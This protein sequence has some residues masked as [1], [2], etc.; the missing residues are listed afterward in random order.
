MPCRWSL[1]SVQ[2]ARSPPAC[3]DRSTSY[4]P[5]RRASAGPRVS[6]S[7]W[8]YLPVALVLVGEVVERVVEPVLDRELAGVRRVGGEVGVDARLP[9][10]VPGPEPP[11]VAAAGL[12]RI[13]W[14]IDV[15]ARGECPKVSRGRCALHDLPLRIAQQHVPPAQDDVD[16][17]GTVRLAGPARLRLRLHREHR[18]VRRGQP[19]RCRLRD[20]SPSGRR[21]ENRDHERAQPHP[22]SSCHAHSVRRP[23]NIAQKVRAAASR[24]ETL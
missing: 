18:R 15:V 4:G 23:S 12:E 2:S 22:A 17:G 19:L 6:K 13:A 10:V 21:D 16:A 14:E 3:W 24:R 7:T 11:R 20:L 1:V 9:A 5:F 8:A